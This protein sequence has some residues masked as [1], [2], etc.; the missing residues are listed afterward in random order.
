MA[1]IE[2]VP[3][4]MIEVGEG[5]RPVNQ[6]RV[7]Q[8]ISSVGA[9]GM[10]TPISV[11]LQ[12]DD[13]GDQHIHLVAG[14]HRLEA[15]RR[16]GW[17]EIDAV[18]VDMDATERQLW[19]IDE[20]L[21]RSELTP[22]E[23]ADCTTRRKALYEQLHPET[24]NGAVGNGREKVRQIGE[25]TP[26]D[27]FTADTARAT[28]KSERAVQRDAE[29]GSKIAPDVLAAIKGTKWDKGVTLDILKKLTHEEQRQAVSRVT[30][31]A[32]DSFESAFEFIRDVEPGKKSAAAV[33]LD[34]AA[35]RQEAE[36]ERK[37]V[38]KLN[39]DQSRVISLSD[40]EQFADWIIRNSSLDEITQIITWLTT[41]KAA[42]VISCLRRQAAWGLE[43]VLSGFGLGRYGSQI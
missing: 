20:N 13:S 15:A 38:E 14:R 29:R 23:A 9:I 22:T 35:A 8:L 26:A 3:V 34:T 27:R 7:D 30:T 31:G 25:A 11:W 16:L 2:R 32:D 37:E 36:R 4:D 12:E 41:T 33:K 5:R 43:L 40:A 21:M 39:R 18:Y 28:G 42:D 17:A 1:I 19:E 10:Q 6:D 24:K